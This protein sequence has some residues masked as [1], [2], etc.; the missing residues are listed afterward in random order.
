MIDIKP[1]EHLGMIGTTGSGKTVF[2][3]FKECV[4]EIP[5]HFY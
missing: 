4:P 5:L 2:K 1:G 3:L